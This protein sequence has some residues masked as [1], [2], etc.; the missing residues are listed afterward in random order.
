M[1]AR[2]R[3]RKTW[4]R[5]EQVENLMLP[6]MYTA[7]V[8]TVSCPQDQKEGAMCAPS[9]S[10]SPANRQGTFRS[11]IVWAGAF[12]PDDLVTTPERKRLQNPA[13]TDD[14]LMAKRANLAGAS[15]PVVRPCGRQPVRSSVCAVVSLCGVSLC[16]VSLC[17]HRPLRSVVPAGGI[18]TAI[19]PPSRYPPVRLR[20]SPLQ[21][22]PASYQFGRCLAGSRP[23]A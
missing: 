7:L 3:W 11:G 6:L 19:S 20:S 1:D 2:S 5:P 16:G 18:S 8:Y 4:G 12:S 13:N 22:R 9:A 17:A 10:K 14:L 23:M 15:A 21:K